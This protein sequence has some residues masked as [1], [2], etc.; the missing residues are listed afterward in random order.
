[1]GGNYA[2]GQSTVV[3]RFYIGMLVT[4]YYLLL[5][6]GYQNEAQNTLNE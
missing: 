2:I 5:S 3:Q 6:K 4:E 1:M